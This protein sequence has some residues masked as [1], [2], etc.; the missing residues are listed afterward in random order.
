MSKTVKCKHC[1]MQNS[2]QMQ[3]EVANQLSKLFQII[4][5]IGKTQREDKWL[6]INWVRG[7]QMVSWDVFESTQQTERQVFHVESRDLDRKWIYF[8]NPAKTTWADLD[9]ATTQIHNGRFTARRSCCASDG[10]WRVSALR[11]LQADETI[12]DNF[13]F[14]RWALNEEIVH[15]LK[16]HYIQ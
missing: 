8:D 12:D 9:E 10:T 14:T 7:T 2:C 11:T 6:R 15:L 4:R 5:S 1:R 13:Y 16:K 3:K